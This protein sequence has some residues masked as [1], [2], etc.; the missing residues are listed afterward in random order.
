MEELSV[1]QV[2]P[3][4][5]FETFTPIVYSESDIAENE[6]F[7]KKPPTAFL[8]P[9]DWSLYVRVCC[10]L[11]QLRTQYGCSE[12][13]AYKQI[14]GSTEER[15]RGSRIVR[16]VA[17]FN[18]LYSEYAMLC[19]AMASARKESR[20]QNSSKGSSRHWLFS[21]D[22]I[23]RKRSRNSASRHRR[24]GRSGLSRS[25]TA[26][27]TGAIDSLGDNFRPAL[28]TFSDMPKE[29]D[30]TP[31]VASIANTADTV[32]T[33]L[34][35][36]NSTT[37]QTTSHC[38]QTLSCNEFAVELEPFQRD[39]KRFFL[40]R[41]GKQKSS[42]GGGNKI[43][44]K[45]DLEVYDCI[46]R[47]PLDYSIWVSQISVKRM[48]TD[49][50]VTWMSNGPLGA[51]PKG[52]V[53]TMR[54]PIG[55][56]LTLPRMQRQIEVIMSTCRFVYDPLEVAAELRTVNYDTDACIAYFLQSRELREIIQEFLPTRTLRPNEVLRHSPTAGQNPSE[57]L[58]YELSRTPVPP[59][60]R[61]ARTKLRSL[62]RARLE[63]ALLTYHRKLTHLKKAVGDANRR[64][65]RLQGFA[66]GLSSVFLQL[67]P[68]AAGKLDQS[69][70]GPESSTENQTA[71]YTQLKQLSSENST[72]K[73]TLRLEMERRMSIF[74]MMQEYLGNIRVYCRCRAI[75]QAGN[76]VEVTSSDTIHLLNGTSIEDYRFDR[77]FDITATQAEVFNELMPLIHS[78]MDGFN[79]CFLAYGGE[80]SGKT[81]TLLGGSDGLQESRGIVQRALNCV[82]A[83]S[84]VKHSEWDIG[85]AVA[86][87]EVYND[88]FID[89]L[90]GETGVHVRVDL[91]VDRMMEGLRTVPIQSGGDI[92][93]LLEL[94][95]SRRRVGKT[96]LNP[97]SSRS[98]LIMLARL[99][100]R[101]RLHE[102][103]ISSVLALCDLAGFEDIIK[104]DTLSDQTLAK[105]AGFINRSLT[106]FNRVFS[107]L[108]TQD[109]MAVSYRDSK[110]TYL[111]KPFF[112]NSGKCILIVTVRTD[113]A[114]L[115]S[116]QG[117]LRF[118]RDSRAVSLGRARRQI[119]VERLMQDNK[120]FY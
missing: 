87:V 55:L 20:A 76:C 95:K 90:S 26:D 106:A 43:V 3:H 45:K 65:K 6:P 86:V 105:E 50:V 83:E 78:F 80:A 103:C 97:A 11:R 30:Q 120:A 57:G 63:S 77:V 2:I 62:P 9:R 100:A 10:H 51:L 111:L 13:E 75:P 98:H 89:L 91:G 107:S 71:L 36:M 112:T 118:G 15:R 25:T 21:G 82:L 38:T 23:G 104:A 116:T 22:G 46:Q 113:R 115:P 7:P 88:V 5:L 33:N 47:Q 14:S 99:Q 34:P 39:K 32:S 4:H 93:S 102:K 101:S 27:C 67:L 108:R 119:S 60:E 12:Y 31:T 28:G 52:S 61:E 70:V 81:Y 1:E 24:R 79:V 17:A 64:L 44:G 109:P 85:L 54:L 74:N 96:A 58:E 29:R 92:E 40:C 19:A 66:G 41:K 59:E 37:V 72:L 114:N 110:L 69:A 117:T 53:E 18:R 68:N 84:A 48:S 56:E 73:E 42:N 16:L 35:S 94:C 49:H 8:A